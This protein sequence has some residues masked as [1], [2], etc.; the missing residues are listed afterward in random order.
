M[1][2]K[3]IALTLLLAGGL[4]TSCIK[5][6]HSECRNV[7][8]LALSYKGDGQTEIFADKINKVNMY[9]FDA[10]NVCVASEVLSEADLEARLAVL[11]ALEPGDYK[12]VCLGNAY[13]T[14]VESL[15]DGGLDQMIFAPE[16]YLS[17]DI[18]TGNDPLYWSMTEYQI[19][20][21]NAKQIAQTR[22]A[23]F[24]SSHY[25][26]YVEVVG[27]LPQTKSADAPVIELVGVSPMTDFT[28]TPK[29]DP[30]TYLMDAAH[31]RDI[32]LTAHT[33]IMRHTDHESVHLRV[34]YP[35]GTLIAEVNFADHIAYNH[36]DVTQQE[37]VIP[38]RVEI[39]PISV[40]ISTPTWFIENITPEF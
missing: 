18:V 38:F 9:V 31:N 25:D 24:E 4:S 2:F 39:S 13:Q 3:N 36:I 8:R 30:V 40:Q 16:A 26:V 23:E 19:A 1:K 20:P 11:P 21:F 35:D 6:D 28:N 29:G 15:S 10:N 27:L 22:T 37:C 5:E 34:S 33:C 17:G 12:V 14:G 32:G 7:Y